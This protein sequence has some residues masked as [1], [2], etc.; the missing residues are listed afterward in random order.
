MSPGS[1]PGPIQGNGSGLDIR[2]VIQAKPT[3]RSISKCLASLVSH[4]NQSLSLNPQ[5]SKSVCF[6]CF[7]PSKSTKFNFAQKQSSGASTI[8]GLSPL[9]PRSL[10]C[11]CST[12][13]VKIACDR[14]QHLLRQKN[15]ITHNERKRNS[16]ESH[17]GLS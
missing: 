10:L 12:V 3:P 9:E 4:A 8:S 13:M 2:T 6:E 1:S 7:N 11:R 15:K 14:R 17:P 16:H 5:P